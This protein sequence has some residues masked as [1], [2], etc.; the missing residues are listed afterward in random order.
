[1]ANSSK[2]NQVTNLVAVPW[3]AFV[4]AFLYYSLL[5]S[6]ALSG[7]QVGSVTVGVAYAAAPVAYGATLLLR[8]ARGAAAWLKPVHSVG[9]SDSITSG[10]HSHA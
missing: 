9:H 3:N 10:A 2:P 5:A 7:A 8:I 1:M 6:V 4:A